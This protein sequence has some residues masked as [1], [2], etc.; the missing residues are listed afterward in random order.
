MRSGRRPARVRRF[1]PGLWIPRRSR[2][3]SPG[4][5]HS[6]GPGN[7]CRAA[8]GQPSSVSG[9]AVCGRGGSGWP[10]TAAGGGAA[11]RRS[12][13]DPAFSSAS[14]PDLS[15]ERKSRGL[16]Q[17]TSARLLRVRANRS[18]D[19]RK[20]PDVGSVST[21]RYFPPAFCRSGARDEGPGAGD[22]S[23]KASVSWSRNPPFP[24]VVFRAGSEAPRRP[25]S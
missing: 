5:P 15:P 12:R 24:G 21:A 4:G 25:S 10:E 6:S 18:F 8:G 2:A 16:R 7:R 9:R 19:R 14:L 3:L 23:D 22:A 11:H 20:G 17:G 1:V 13:H